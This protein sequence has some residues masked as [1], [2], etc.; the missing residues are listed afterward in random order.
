LQTSSWTWLPSNGVSQLVPLV[1]ILL[2]LAVRSGG[3]PQ[4]AGVAE[5]LIGRAPVPR[6]IPLATV[7]GLAVAVL[8]LVLT[9]HSWRAAVVTSIILAVLA[10]SQVVITGYAG[11]VSL[12]QLTLAGASAFVLGKMTTSLGLPFPIPVVLA[13]LGAM[14]LG[15][16]I[17]IPALRVR[18]LSFAVVTLALAVAI[19]SVWFLNP[20]LNGGTS[21]QPIGSPKFLG[22]DLSIGSGLAYPRLAFCF[23]CLAILT[24][25]AIGVALLRRSRLGAE[26]LAVRANERSAAASGIDVRRVKVLA[27]A[28][29]GFIAGLS[30]ALIAYQ[31]QVAI[32]GSYSVLT[33]I[34]LFA[35]VYLAGVSSVLGGLMAGL[36]S[37]GGVVYLMAD[38]WVNLNEYYVVLSGIA[39]VVTVILNPDGSVAPIHRAIERFRNR[40]KAEI[41]EA[42][43]SSVTGGADALRIAPPPTGT[44]GE[45]LLLANDVGV[46]YGGVVALEDVTFTVK[47]GEILGVIGP[48]GAGKTTLIDALSGF[49]KYTGQVT[50]LSRELDSL[51]P[52]R[53]IRSGLGRTFQSIELYDDLTVEE[54]VKV[55]MTAGKSDGVEAMNDFLD[56]LGLTPVRDRTVSELSQGQRQ[57]VSVARALAGKPE[58]LLL[59]EP[60]AGLDSS[61]SEWLGE[62]LKAVRDWG[63]TVVIVDH[64]MGLVLGICDRI[65]VLDLGKKIADDVPAK[66]KRD[67]SVVAAY[68]GSTHAH[69]EIAQPAT[70]LGKVES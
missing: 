14:L 34:G 59:D 37:T 13:A 42:A 6:N 35:L 3:I 68:L 55:G 56:V 19:E 69:D 61:E 31:Q 64:D 18:G 17:G 62:R 32:A 44:A 48:N 57:L 66:V 21:G 23:T 24:L 63:V 11:Q 16:V 54:N 51:P 8:A 40:D 43:I 33:G 36:I 45:Q 38:R 29:S 50:L 7:T 5:R 41:P 25:V 60:A 39:L 10:L 15:V 22:I 9:S 12:G 49:A 28:I 4:R 52:F 67:P 20:D 58:V 53:R 1:L 30:G 2:L 27:F 65:V 46:S 26:M 70:S 47:R